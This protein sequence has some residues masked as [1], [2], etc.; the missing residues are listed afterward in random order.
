MQ[1]PMI[2]LPEADI[3]LRAGAFVL[4]LGI[5]LLAETRIP[6]RGLSMSRLPRWLSNLSLGTLN[7]L[8][9]RFGWPFLGYGLAILTEQR[10]WGLFHL[11]ALPHWLGF[12]LSLLLLDLLVWAQ[13]RLFHRLPVL[14]RMHRLHHADP[15]LDVTTAVRFHPFEAILSMLIKSAAILILGVTP[16]AFLVFEVVLSS[17][18]LFNHGNIRLPQKVDRLLRFFVV[19]PDMH[20]VHHSTRRV[21]Q[22]HNFG[23]NLPWWDRIFGTYQAQPAQGHERMSIGLGVFAGVADQRLDRLL[24]QPFR[25]EPATDDR[26]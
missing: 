3:L 10:Q 13:H 12:V 17:T 1:T 26:T 6:R 11:L 14:W 24:A 7:I 16:L 23:F 2:T 25:A 15:D 19:T 4:L 9:L 22:N 18:A 20:R 8:L 5:L 21:E